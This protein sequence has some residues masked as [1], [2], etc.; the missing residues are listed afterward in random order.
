MTRTTLTDTAARLP[1]PITAL[2]A[3]LCTALCMQVM[4]QESDFV[5]VT[6]EMVQ[7]PDPADWLT[8]RRTL[9]HWGYSP[10]D[11]IDRDNVS[12]LHAR[13][14]TAADERSAGRHTARL[15]RRHVFPEPG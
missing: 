1:A 9:D 4:A 15:R 3:A 10:L 11:Q 6:D 7:N 14:D 2:A 12:R 8:W 13:V 5:P